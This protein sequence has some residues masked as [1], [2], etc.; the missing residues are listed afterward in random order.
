[1]KQG[2]YQLVTSWRPIALLESSY[3]LLTLNLTDQLRSWCLENRII[4]PLQKSLGPAEGCLEHNFL[5]KYLTEY[6]DLY[7]NKTLHLAF[8][9]IKEVFPNVS[10]KILIGILR[11]I[12]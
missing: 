8:L 2:Q 7:E 9:D 12:G 4:H 1:M 11:R 6:V 5:I 3:K 10:Q